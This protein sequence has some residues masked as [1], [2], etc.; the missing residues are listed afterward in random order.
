MALPSLPTIEDELGSAA[1]GSKLTST[2]WNSVLRLIEA[3]SVSGELRTF[4]QGIHVGDD[5]HF[6]KLN[7]ASRK[8]EFGGDARPT[9]KRPFIQHANSGAGISI[10]VGYY[11]RYLS[12]GAAD[13]VYG[14]FDTDFAGIDTSENIAVKVA[15][16]C[17]SAPTGVVAVINHGYG[18]VRA[19]GTKDAIVQDAGTADTLTGLNETTFTTHTIETID[20]VTANISEGATL[21]YL[22]RRYGASGSD[23]VGAAIGYVESRGLW[24]EYRA[25]ELFL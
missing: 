9:V 4:P 3:L 12:D 15:W 24:V 25:K 20:P 10:G 6:I 19:D 14:V 22:L 23:D 7:A 17:N 1:F 13:I 21:G 5:V 18:V 16:I 2:Q 8:I 11:I